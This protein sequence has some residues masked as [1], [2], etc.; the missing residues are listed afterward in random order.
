MDN[1]LQD[2]HP[3]S[4]L[5][6]KPPPLEVS[7]PGFGEPAGQKLNSKEGGLFPIRFHEIWPLQNVAF[8]I[9]FESKIESGNS[10]AKTLWIPNV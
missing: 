3:S 10:D 2:P 1:A 7:D 6:I 9:G 4:E 5:E 8:P